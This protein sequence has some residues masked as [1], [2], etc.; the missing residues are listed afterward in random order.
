MVITVRQGLH[1]VNLKTPQ[2]LTSVECGL[3][4]VKL[5]ASRRKIDIVAYRRL[6]TTRVNW[7]YHNP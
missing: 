6:I 3:R 7:P 4:N 2:R 1:D 5:D